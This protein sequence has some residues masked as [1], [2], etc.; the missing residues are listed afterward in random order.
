[1]TSSEIFHFIRER[2]RSERERGGELDVYCFVDIYV[3]FFFQ[4]ELDDV[5]RNIYI[6]IYIYDECTKSAASTTTVERTT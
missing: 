6:R 3:S 4:N 1:M 5:K 2:E